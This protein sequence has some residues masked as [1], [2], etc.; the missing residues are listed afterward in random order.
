[1]PHGRGHRGEVVD[2]PGA[3]EQGR[4]AADPVGRVRRQA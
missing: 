3:D 4:G 2:R 1:M